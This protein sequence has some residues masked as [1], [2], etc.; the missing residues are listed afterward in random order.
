MEKIKF[1][2]SV[3]NIW[4]GIFFLIMSVLFEYVAIWDFREDGS[5]GMILMVLFTI[6]FVLP[7][8]V[9][10]IMAILSYFAA[11]KKMSHKL[12]EYGE[13]KILANIERHTL[14]TYSGFFGDKTYFTDKL[15]VDP[16]TA[17]IDYNEISYMYLSVSSYKTGGVHRLGLELWDG[18]KI[19]ICNGV[20]NTQ[21]MQMMQLCFQHNSQIMCGGSKKNDATQKKRVA[22]FK[23]GKKIIPC[24]NL[25]DDFTTPISQEKIQVQ[26]VSTQT[27]AMSS[28]AAGEYVAKNF[29][30]TENLAAIKFYREATGVGLAEAKAAVDRIF[31]SRKSEGKVLRTPYEWTPEGEKRDNAMVKK[32]GGIII[33][34]TA[35]FLWAM[36]AIGEIALM[37]AYP[38]TSQDV[39]LVIAFFIGYFVVFGGL[40][41][42]GLWLFKKGK[43]DVSMI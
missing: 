33:M 38:V 15:I 11:R 8:A 29:L 9:G 42:F 21:I 39:P 32:V 37:H 26:A 36:M 20:K 13:D 31:A 5:D 40:F 10:G 17:I 12:Q 3:V 25:E 22:E 41:L 14:Y 23:N 4:L 19:I 34:I 43:D 18:T 2:T 24:L 6:F 35:F 30:P 28:S 27:T 16:K 7:F 1:K